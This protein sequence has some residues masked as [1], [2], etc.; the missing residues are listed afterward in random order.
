MGRISKVGI[1]TLILAAS[2]LMAWSWCFGDELIQPTRT[3]GEPEKSWGSLTVFSEP[4]ELDV[5]LDGEKVGPTPLWLRQVET[6][7]HKVK[8]NETEGDVRVEKGKAARIGLFKGS[9]VTFSQVEE[10]KAAPEPARETRSQ[11]LSVPQ[12]LQKAEKEDLTLW[13][14]FVNGSLKHF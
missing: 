9:F 12:P 5:Y 10:K 6:G 8:I 14:R 4:P 7:P 1:L 11:P 3:L 2:G 13:E